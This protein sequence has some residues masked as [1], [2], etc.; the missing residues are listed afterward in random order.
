MSK[1]GIKRVPKVGE[2]VNI[3][4]ECGYDGGVISAKVAPSPD[5]E[6]VPDNMGVVFLAVKGQPESGI[7]FHVAAFIW[8]KGQWDVHAVR[9][10]ADG[11]K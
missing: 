6:P 10:R 9:E 2:A 3:R 1:K 5:R 11:G 7:A 4:L 8:N